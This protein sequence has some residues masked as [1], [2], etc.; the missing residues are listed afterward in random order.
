MVRIALATVSLAA[1]CICYWTV[2]AQ[3]PAASSD[4][5]HLSQDLRTLL[6]AEMSEIAAASQ[7]IVTAYVSGDWKAIQHIS[8]QIRDSYVMKQSISDAQK[9][10]LQDKLPK[11][12]KQLDLEF[13]A[14]A[15]KLGL[16]AAAEDPEL[17]AFH[18]SR[19][20]EACATCHAAYA[21]TRFP[22]FSS[23]PPDAHHH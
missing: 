6:Q 3:Q 15:N 19:L 2:S 17:V 23:E 13:H 5:I 22:A 16:A 21:K 14:R 11:R 10:E 1:V 12:F 7:S 4:E 18:Y 20:L 8:E 9:Q